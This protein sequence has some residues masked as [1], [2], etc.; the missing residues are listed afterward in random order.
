[1][2]IRSATPADISAVLPMVAATCT[3]H[4]LWDAAKYGFLPNPEQRYERWLTRLFHNSS[5]RICRE[6]EDS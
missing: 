2:L 3:L 6:I 4:E 1:M 5:L